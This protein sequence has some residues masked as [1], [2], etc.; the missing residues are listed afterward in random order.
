[1]RRPHPP[2]LALDAVSRTIGNDTGALMAG[3]PG[4][5][6]QGYMAVF[7]QRYLARAGTRRGS[8]GFEFTRAQ[9]PG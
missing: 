2:A 7:S 5:D 8:A 4:C 3:F 1:M 9:L 6:P